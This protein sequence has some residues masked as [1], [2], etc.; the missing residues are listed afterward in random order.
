MKQLLPLVCCRLQRQRRHFSLSLSLTL[1]SPPGLCFF[2]YCFFPFLFY[3]FQGVKTMFVAPIIGCSQT[4]YIY[5]YIEYTLAPVSRRL[6]RRYRHYY[7]HCRSGA[8]IF[9]RTS[10]SVSLPAS[11]RNNFL[12]D[13]TFLLLSALS[14]CTIARDDAFA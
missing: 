2:R 9:I 7:H 12:S 11:K 3:Y 14:C 6:H 5:V 1:P 10:T 13:E 8:F 4:L